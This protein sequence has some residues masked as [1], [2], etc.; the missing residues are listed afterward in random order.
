MPDKVKLEYV[1]HIHKEGA[2]YHVLSWGG[3]YDSKGELHGERYCSEPRCVINREA[4]LRLS[5]LNTPP[6][7]LGKMGGEP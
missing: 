6:V 4:D 5:T 7:G 1:P 3:Y 2:R